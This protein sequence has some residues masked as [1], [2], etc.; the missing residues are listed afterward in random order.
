MKTDTI[1]L[2]GG[3][4]L[5]DKNPN[6][7]IRGAYQSTAIKAGIGGGGGHSDSYWAFLTGR[8]FHEAVNNPSTDWN[9]VKV[10][11]DEDSI[12]WNFNDG[13]WI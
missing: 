2:R 1:R 3:F 13:D 10:S 9:T 5:L 7:Q 8:N 12:N 4:T 6:A 11:V